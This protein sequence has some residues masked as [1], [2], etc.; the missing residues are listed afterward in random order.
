MVSFRDVH[1]VGLVWFWRSFQTKTHGLD[2]SQTDQTE[3]IQMWS[4]WIDLGCQFRLVLSGRFGP[5]VFND[6]FTNSEKHF[7]YLNHS[8]N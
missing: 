7:N 6:Y 8:N 4:F 1:K 2:S 3:P 5:F